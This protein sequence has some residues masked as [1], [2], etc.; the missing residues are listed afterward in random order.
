VG[1]LIDESVALSVHQKTTSKWDRG[2]ESSCV[3]W[4]D[5]AVAKEGAHLGQGQVE[6]GGPPKRIAS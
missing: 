3:T 6:I 2:I 5:E 4:Y 1:V